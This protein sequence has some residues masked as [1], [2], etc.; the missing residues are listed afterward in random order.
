MDAALIRRP[1]ATLMLA[2][3]CLAVYVWQ[4]VA[5]ADWWDASADDLLRLG[6][7]YAPAIALGEVWRAPASLFLHGS[8]LHLAVNLLALLDIGRRVERTLG[9]ARLLLAFVA[10]GLAGALAS[11]LAHP[12]AIALGASGGIFGLFAL[13]LA[14]VWRVGERPQR[15]RLAMVAAYA[16]VALGAG[17]FVAGVDNAAHLAGFAAGALIALAL[18]R[19]HGGERAAVAAA[20][21]IGIV[22]FAGQSFVPDGGAASY[23]EGMRF[24]ALY[25]EFAAV[26]REVNRELRAIGSAARERRISDVEAMARIDRAAEQLAANAALWERERF[27]TPTPEAARQLW[28]RYTRLRIDAIAALRTTLRPAHAAPDAKADAEALAR[29]EANMREAAALVESIRR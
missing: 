21:A 6:A 28:L 23:R 9:S 17:F 13:D 15:T 2:A 19:P 8:L 12:E 29:F 1:R 10:T 27:T 25:R 26:D 5:G 7:I 22:A 4:V 14:A 3:I 24:D 18:H 20:L 16:I 11:A